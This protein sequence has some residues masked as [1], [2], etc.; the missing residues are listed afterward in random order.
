MRNASLGAIVSAI[1][2][3]PN[4]EFAPVVEGPGGFLPDLPSRLIA[5]GNISAVEYNGGHCTGDGKTFASGSPDQFVTDEDVKRIVF[6]RWPGV[7]RFVLIVI[8]HAFQCLGIISQRNSEM[9]L[10]HYIRSQMTLAGSLLSG[11][12]R[13]QWQDRLFSLAC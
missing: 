3:V 4:G 5:S 9:R 13:G 6:S 7:V 2:G 11:I 12:E 1:N 10:W 8:R